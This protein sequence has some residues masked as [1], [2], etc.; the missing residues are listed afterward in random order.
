MPSMF[1][2]LGVNSVVSATT[3]QPY[4]VAP[5]GAVQALIADVPDL[6][7]RGFT[8]TRQPLILGQSGVPV[9]LPSSGTSNASGQITLTTALP[10]QPSGVVGL[11]LPAGVVTGG[12]QGSSAGVYL[13]TFSS[14][15]V[16]QLTGTGIVTANSAYT[17]TTGTDVTLV[18]VVVP[19]GSMGLNGR[20]RVRSF[21]QHPNNANAKNENVK[22]AG[23]FV[24]AFSNTT[25]NAVQALWEM[26][27]KG[28]QNLNMRWNVSSDNAPF[29]SN[30][31]QTT[32]DMSQLQT[33]TWTAQLAVATDYVIL[34]GYGIEV[35]PQ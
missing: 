10:Y 9:I 29:A 24:Q 8:F 34:E 25:T 22:L 17:Q 2:P 1:A 13:A 31:A 26:I 7:S 23:Q 3:G 18:S 20:L 30:F 27:N 28:A 32:F 4:S 21:W 19:A 35:L 15:T 14:T 12:S 11:Y 6:L 16:C 33:M 5:G